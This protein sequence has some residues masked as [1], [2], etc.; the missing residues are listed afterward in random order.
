METQ[1]CWRCKQY[2]PMFDEEEFAVL[3]ALYR[4]CVRQIRLTDAE[5]FRPLLEQHERMTGVFIDNHNAIIH[6][7]RSLYGPSCANCGKAL[8]TPVASKC[9][10]CGAAAGESRA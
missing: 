9:Y 4:A 10:E 6:H 7:R 1:W 5:R 3:G 2:L 8:R